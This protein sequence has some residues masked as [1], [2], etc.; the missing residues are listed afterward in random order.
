MDWTTVDGFQTLA[1]AV[2]R[3]PFG[4]TKTPGGLSLGVK[5]LRRENEHFHLAQRFRM[6]LRHTFLQRGAYCLCSW[7][8]HPFRRRPAQK[9]DRVPARNW[10]CLMW[11]RA[12]AST[13]RTRGLEENVY[14]RFWHSFNYSHLRIKSIIVLF[15]VGRSKRAKGPGAV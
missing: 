3:P 12:L 5:R 13:V 15:I 2:S 1:T 10:P 7:L 14:S 9:W 6:P 4:P 11:L 8:L